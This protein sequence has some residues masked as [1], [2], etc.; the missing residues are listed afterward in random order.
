MMR[1]GMLLLLV[2]LCC[3]QVVA[4]ICNVL[5]YGAV[6]DGARNDREELQRALKECNEVVLPA[7]KVFLSGSL[8]L[9]SHQVVTIDGELRGVSPYEGDVNENWPFIYS[10][11][12]GTMTMT[13]ASLVNGGQCLELD[14]K[15]L[16]LGDQCQSWNKLMNVTISGK[17]TINGGG[18]QGWWSDPRID[19]NRPTLLGLSWITDLEISYLTF[20][21]PA[22]WTTHILFCDNV[23]VHDLVIDTVGVPNG[24]GIDPDS[25]TNVLI[26]DCSI[27]SSD[28]VIA[29][30]SGKN[31]DGLAVARPS[32]NITVRNMQFLEGHGVAIGSET[33]GDIRGVHMYNLDLRGTDRGVRIKSQK[34]RGGVVE[35]IIYENMTFADVETAISITM[36]YTHDGHGPAPHFQNIQ[37]KN[38]TGTGTIEEVGEVMCLPE[39]PCTGMMFEDIDLSVAD[40]QEYE[41]QEVHGEVSNVKPSMS[42]CVV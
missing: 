38:I 25:S 31:Q 29:I 42:G 9:K 37:V 4:Q 20:T 14:Y 10:R 35:N 30:K 39:S 21:N 12:G 34:G 11:R 33:S 6:G 23:H 7:G 8:F 2:T 13:R 19:G 3:V 41:C 18:D 28:D 22:F 26:E 16:Y 36:Y 15:P 32:E 5:D 40:N 27:T 17:G 24:D 1:M